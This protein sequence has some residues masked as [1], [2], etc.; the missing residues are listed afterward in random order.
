M[1]LR[2]V[3]DTALSKLE[4]APAPPLAPYD[5]APPAPPICVI[6][7]EVWV[8]NIPVKVAPLDAD[9]EPLAIPPLPPEYP[10][11]IAAP[12]APPVMVSDACT[13]VKK[14]LLPDTVPT[15]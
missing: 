3:A 10:T 14:G 5:P 4:S 7:A 11:P 8:E 12:P 13:V 2:L 9:A 15:T 6:W 1:L